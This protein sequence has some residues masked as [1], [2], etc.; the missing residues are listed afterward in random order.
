[1]G[2]NKCA[3]CKAKLHNS[4]VFPKDFPDE[5]RF[6]CN[7][8]GLA[9]ILASYG[10]TELV[11]IFA[12]NSSLSKNKTVVKRIKKIDELTNVNKCVFLP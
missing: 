3:I 11:Q 7:C 9:N 6:C 12:K 1:M 5:W 2:K 10:Y 8:S 4:A